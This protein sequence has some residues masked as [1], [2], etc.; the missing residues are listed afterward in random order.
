MVLDKLKNFV[1][2][3]EKSS[4]GRKRKK[5]LVE[6]TE[7]EGGRAPPSM[8]TRKGRAGGDRSALKERSGGKG[9]LRMPSEKDLKD[10]PEIPESGGKGRGSRTERGGERGTG[11]GNRSRL[12]RSPETKSPRE[13]QG[14]ERP[15]ERGGSAPRERMNTDEALRRIL[16]K[17]DQ[18][19]RKLERLGRR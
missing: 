1:K 9:N 11:G 16:D 18:I 7:E 4:E 3:K 17:L 5:K 8:G 15:A 2:G 12:P 10:L 19:D 14:P 6:E 13:R